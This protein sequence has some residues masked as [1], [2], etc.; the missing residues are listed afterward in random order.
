M[1][2]YR[3]VDLEE[4]RLIYAAGMRGFP[5]RRPEQPIF[6]PVLNREYAD[7]IAARWNATGPTRSGYV[8]AF[9]VD[10]DYVAGF[11]AEVVGAARHA[12]LWIPAKELGRFNGRLR[13]AIEVVGAHFGEAFQGEI[14]TDGALRGRDATQQFA[15]LVGV[16]EFG[17]DFACEIHFNH[18]AVFL[19]YAFWAQADFR[20]QGVDAPTRDR[21]LAD[22]RSVWAGSTSHVEL[23]VKAPGG[24]SDDG[25]LG[26]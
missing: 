24:E 1:R 7:E 9:D 8:T 14:G 3:P 19:N 17:M 13:G 26:A 15:Y 16:R 10:D 23:P 22:V 18:A 25:A 4:L 11:K 6:Y 5:P 2:L 21:I 12:E 20:P